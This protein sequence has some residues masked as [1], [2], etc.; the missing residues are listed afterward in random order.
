M[1]RAMLLQGIRQLKQAGMA[2]AL[3]GVDAQNL[4]HAQDL[5]ISVGFR[6]TETH[7]AYEKEP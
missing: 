2:T 7:I 3:L 5:Y 1:A 4:N 6:V